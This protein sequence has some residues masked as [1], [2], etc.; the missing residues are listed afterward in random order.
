MKPIQAFLNREADT[1]LNLIDAFRDLLPHKDNDASAHSGEEGR[2][3]EIVV[4]QYLR[5]KLP[6]GLEVG[7]G[8]LIDPDQS[9]QSRQLDVII[10]DSHNFAPF[11]RYGDA[12]VAHLASAVAVISIKRKLYKRDLEPEIRILSEIGARFGNYHLPKPFLS[13]VGFD[14]AA[15][16]FSKSVDDVKDALRNFYSP[17]P[18]IKNRAIKFSWGE[19][20]DAV[21]VPDQFLVRLKNL[22]EPSA[23]PPEAQKYLWTGGDGKHRHIYWQTL[24][25]GIRR[26]YFDARRSRT[27]EGVNQEYFPIADMSNLAQISVVPV[28]RRK[29]SWDS[30]IPAPK[31]FGPFEREMVGKNGDAAGPGTTNK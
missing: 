26:R 28:V 3:I 30:F 8:F 1:L 20:V 18:D 17:R 19:L 31:T 13:L 24:L 10:F 29:Y 23:K 12:I 21:V 2:A 4:R 11:F 15:S 22:D 16:D 25:R 7:C 6:A 27:L 5:E 9:W 14:T